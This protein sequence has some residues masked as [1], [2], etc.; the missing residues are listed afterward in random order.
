[1]KRKLLIATC[2]VMIMIW[3]G[4]DKKR[5]TQLLTQQQQTG[6]ALHKLP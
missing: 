1:M 2:K 4:V 3:Y 6:A 5:A